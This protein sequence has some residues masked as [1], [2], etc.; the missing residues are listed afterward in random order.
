VGAFA[1][2]AVFHDVGMWGLRDGTEF[3]TAGGFFLFIGVGTML[4]YGFKEVTGRRVGGLC[5]WV[6]QCGLWCGRLVGA[7][8]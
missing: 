8:C 4:E 1:V 7:L 3:P 6:C 2:S 5:G